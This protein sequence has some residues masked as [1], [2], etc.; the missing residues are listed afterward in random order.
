MYIS[1]HTNSQEFWDLIDLTWKWINLLIAIFDISSLTSNALRL[2]H[3]SRSVF[4]DFS[5][6]SERLLWFFTNLRAS[7]W[8]NFEQRSKISDA[9]SVWDFLERLWNLWYQK[10][11]SKNLQYADAP[12]S[13]TCTF[14]MDP[15]SGWSGSN[16]I[17][18]RTVISAPEIHWREWNDWITP[19]KQVL[20]EPFQKYIRAWNA[21][22]QFRRHLLPG[23]SILHFNLSF[24]FLTKENKE[25]NHWTFSSLQSHEIK[26]QTRIRIQHS[27]PLSK[28]LVKA[29]TKF[30]LTIMS[31]TDHLVGAVTAN[32]ST[33]FPLK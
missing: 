1:D 6:I 5:Q 8:F 20:K 7:A 29:D 23:V 13:Q 22:M 10:N 21:N 17:S 26:L 31:D 18:P 32:L 3:K 4:Y 16:K 12:V 15:G 24:P 11:P 30:L 33:R 19:V 28:P 14:S 2:F 25:A 27:L 9:P